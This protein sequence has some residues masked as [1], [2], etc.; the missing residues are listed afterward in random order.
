M[1]KFPL[2]V[3]Q[4]D[5]LPLYIGYKYELREVLIVKEIFNPYILD[6]SET[7]TSDASLY[8]PRTPHDDDATVSHRHESLTQYLV[9]YVQGRPEGV[10][11]GAS[12]Q[13]PA[14]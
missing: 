1:G 2:I 7:S 9:R 5:S 13:G 3:L 12:A 4:E 10:S 6:V 8:V 11:N 14:F